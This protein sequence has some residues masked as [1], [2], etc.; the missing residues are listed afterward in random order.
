MWTTQMIPVERR[1]RETLA[2]SEEFEE[3]IHTQQIDHDPSYAKTKSCD[4]NSKTC[5]KRF[6]FEENKAYRISRHEQR[7]NDANVW[8]VMLPSS[9]E[10]L[11][12][13]LEKLTS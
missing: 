12:E 8:Q 13:Q 4:A 6:S 2:M 1:L 11:L 3:T 10:G 5:C 7:P 9:A